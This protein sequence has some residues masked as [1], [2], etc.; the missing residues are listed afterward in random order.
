MI[1]RNILKYI[2]VNTVTSPLKVVSSILALIYLVHIRAMN[3]AISMHTRLE[4]HEKA[5][6]KR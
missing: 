6:R 2:L 3:R 1:K 5:K 4:K